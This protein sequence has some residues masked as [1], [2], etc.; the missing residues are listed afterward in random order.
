M[1]S[2]KHT[3]IRAAASTFG[4]FETLSQFL[5]DVNTKKLV[6]FGETHG[7]KPIIALQKE[8][9]QS[10]IGENKVNVIMEHFSFEMQDILEEYQEGKI[11]INQLGAKYK[12]IGTEGHDVHAYEELLELAR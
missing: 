11:D 6:F 8:V 2:V 4:Q 10:M 9:L 12:E 7:E 5:E 3:F 1:N